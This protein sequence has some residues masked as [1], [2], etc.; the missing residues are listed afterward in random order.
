MENNTLKRHILFLHIALVFSLLMQYSCNSLPQDV[1][2]NIEKSGTN[3]E[4]LLKVIEHYKSDKQKLAAAYFLISNMDGRNSRVGDFSDYNQIYAFIDSIKQC[5]LPKKEFYKQAN[6]KLAELEGIYGTI[7]SK[8][9][10]IKPDLETIKADY[11]ISTI[12]RA[13]TVWKNKP[14]CKDVDF[15]TF[16]E[17]IL[18]YRVHEEPLSKFREF[19][20]DELAWLEDSM[21]EPADIEE[22]CLRVNNFIAQKYT[23]V[24]GLGKIPL[25]SA[26][27]MYRYAAG[28]CEHR[29]ALAVY[30]MRSL[31]IPVAIDYSPQWNHWPGKHSWVSLIK[32]GGSLPFNAGEL[33][34]S[35]PHNNEI[36][37]GLKVSSTVFRNTFSKNR[38]TP[39]EFE[40]SKYNVPANFRTSRIVT[41]T[42]EYN[43]P[44]T[45]L[46][47]DLSD[48]QR[49]KTV[50]LGCFGYGKEIITVG[51]MKPGDSSF[52]NVGQ[53]GIYIPYHFTQNKIEFLSYPFILSC[54]T[55]ERWY[56]NPLMDQMD[57][58]L[59]SRKFDLQDSMIVFS[60]NMQGGCFIGSNSKNF[61]VHDTLAIIT[62]APRD[63]ASASISNN[64]KYR[65][66]KYVPPHGKRIN[67]AE[68][69]LL[70]GSDT[71]SGTPIGNSNTT[72]AN[73]FDTN[74]RTNHNAGKGSWAGIDLGKAQSIT[75]IR[76]L[77]RNNFNIVEPGDI[78]ELFYFDYEWKSL[79]IQKA[80]SN[81]LTYAVPKYSLLLLRDLTKGRE[82]RI[83]KYEGGKQIFW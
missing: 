82:E 24:E 57:T 7:M 51:W 68:I 14:W 74:I 60:A 75:Q 6:A 54:E 56:S 58:A 45:E 39:I 70:S 20:M 81:S 2:Q 11:L 61:S 15:D 65:F 63:F 34:D 36:P 23:F 76:Y 38:N 53:C 80:R 71:L 55:N 31:G 78:Y 13:F 18:P 5:K 12:D 42:E 48:E 47:L 50:Y 40:T 10:E 22:A 9:A 21:S 37:I 4:E 27:D 59:I 62:E 1:A 26:T 30:V 41:V 73:L 77:P 17:Y 43:F 28:E 19:F 35:L 29:Y 25:A 72:E 79:G 16:C 66:V 33:Y 67:I 52:G 3:K 46:A 49:E 8:P 83:F 64:R 32:K 69:Q 44:M